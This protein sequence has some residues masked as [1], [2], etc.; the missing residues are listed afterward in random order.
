MSSRSSDA[1]D[2]ADATARLG[3]KTITIGDSGA[4]SYVTLGDGT[5]ED[6]EVPLA[7]AIVSLTR[8]SLTRAPTE[9]RFK[10]SGTD[11]W[12]TMGL[13]VLKATTG[14]IGNYVSLNTEHG[15]FTARVGCTVRVSGTCTWYDGI[16]GTGIKNRRSLGV[17]INPTVSGSTVSGG[18][19]NSATNYF[20][21]NGT[22][23][24]S[25]TFA[26][27]L[28]HL[29]AG[30][31]LV[32]ARWEPPDAVNEGLYGMTWFTVEVVEVD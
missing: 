21:S 12:H 31:T 30:N 7:Q 23:H 2:A 26:P 3:V 10:W 14:S 15:T 24:K 20:P 5:G 27:K 29:N 16:Y 19:E 18:T 25:V 22:Y 9:I 17:F 8:P 4:Y 11:G 28:F 32:V 1:Y 13:Q 6:T